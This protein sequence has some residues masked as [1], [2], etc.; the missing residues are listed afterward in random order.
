MLH[1]NSRG[2]TRTV[3]CALLLGGLL[4]ACSSSASEIGT[5]LDAQPS[6]ELAP[7][8]AMSIGQ[9]T[10]LQAIHETSESLI[11]KCMKSQGWT[12]HPQR[13]VDDAAL[14]VRDRFGIVD[15][16]SAA[17]NG[18]ETLRPVPDLTTY[19]PDSIGAPTDPTQQEAYYAALNGTAVEI[20]TPPGTSSDAI[21]M[22]KGGCRRQAAD[23]IWGSADGH[24]SD[25][26]EL[27]HLVAVS[28][29]KSSADRQQVAADL[30]WSLCMAKAGYTFPSPQIAL[31]TFLRRP[32]PDAG[33][34]VPVA[35]ADVGCKASTDYVSKATSIIRRHQSALAEKNAAWLA[36]YR[37]AMTD[38]VQ[39]SRGLL[40]GA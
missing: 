22:T 17:A 6:N 13:F 14:S 29:S 40:T 25:Q 9:G 24:V 2:V 39:K 5:T 27:Q 34:E 21:P 28:L 16:V 33:T 32:V 7:L 4:T 3:C 26:A 15:R 12:Y 19:S 18:Y 30:A 37:K 23:E 36:S 11:S 10:D 1:K 35:V 31:Q 38:A 8:D 20:S